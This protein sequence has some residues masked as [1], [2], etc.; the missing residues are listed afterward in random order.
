MPVVPGHQVVGMV[1][2][3]GRDAAAYAASGWALP[4]CGTPVEYAR[5]ASAVKKILCESSRFT[6]Y[7]ADGGYAE[8]AIVPE[9]FAYAI[10]EA[11]TTSMP[12][13]CSVRASSA[14]GPCGGA[15][16]R[17]R[18]APFGFGSSAHVVIQIAQHRGCSVYVVTRG[19]R[20]VALA[21]Q[22]GAVWAGQRAEEW[23]VK[24]DSAIIFA[25]AGELVPAG[26]GVA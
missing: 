4:G 12:C 17:P 16:C 1:D 14:I 19:E 23:P 18:G 10:P 5:F 8:Y 3:L 20:H 15:S 9:I 6:G 13:R 21:R 25:S 7:Q 22:M 26:P 2:A 24:V 11:F